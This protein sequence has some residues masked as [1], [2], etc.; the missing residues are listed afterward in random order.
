MTFQLIEHNLH[1]LAVDGRRLLYHVPTSALFELDDLAGAVIDTLRQGRFEGAKEIENLLTPRFKAEGVRETLAEFRQMQL[2]EGGVQTPD[3]KPVE[4]SGE[5]LTTLILNVNTG[6]NLSCTYCYK[7][8][9]TT[10]AKGDLMELETARQAIDL[11]LDQTP[12]GGVS[13]L[14][15][16]GGE[17]LSNMGLIRDAVS[18]AEDKAERHS[19]TLDFS[20]TTNGTLLSDDLITYLDDHRFGVTVSMDGPKALHDR[21]RKTI[22]GKGTYEENYCP[23]P[24]PD[25]WGRG[26]L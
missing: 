10:P 11:L 17:P 23:R 20:L 16:F 21:N 22:G 9:L 1:E 24:G 12:A 13:N 18:Y 15:F 19:V 4:L 25:R 7:E 26:S 14:V 3:T 6:C 8:D 2:I 5:G